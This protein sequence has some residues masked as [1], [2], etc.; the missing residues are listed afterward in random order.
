MKC[1][2]KDCFTC[3][4]PDCI[5]DY[6]KKTQTYSEKQ[7]AEK[8]KRVRA[9]KDMYRNLGICPYCGKRKIDDGHKMCDFCRTYFRLHK[10]KSQHKHGVLPKELL[11]G[12]DRCS[13]C[14]RGLPVDG[15]SLCTSC[16]Q[17]ARTALSKTPTHNGRK[18]DN[19]MKKVH[20]A[21]WEEKLSQKIE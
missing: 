1:R 2:T 7:L 5:N 16:L 20:N 21:W 13:R 3:P 8:A 14:G 17:Q 9:R 6:V 4:Y 11:D 10:N 12:I 18:V 15:Y 19:Y